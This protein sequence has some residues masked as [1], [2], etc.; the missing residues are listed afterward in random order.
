M[1]NANAA[2]IAWMR[3]RHYPMPGDIARANSMSD[4]ELRAAAGNGGTTAQILYV[5]RALDNYSARMK[6]G[7]YT[8]WEASPLSDIILMMRK[9]LGSGSPYAGYLFAAESRPRHPGSVESN[10]A[11]RLAGLVWASKRGDTRAKRLM[12]TPRIQAVDA[13]TA[14]SAMSLMLSRAL[15]ANPT[16]FSTPVTPIP[17]SGH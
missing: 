1:E 9:I 12:N 16:V 17:A 7:G 10:A 4:A 2:Q 11:R 6:R 3:E 13:A 5:A 8:R 14:G 15:Y